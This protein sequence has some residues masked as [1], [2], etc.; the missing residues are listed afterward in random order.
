MS[1]HRHIPMAAIF[2]IVLL[3]TACINPFQTSY[4]ESSADQSNSSGQTTTLRVSSGGI[5]AATIAPDLAVLKGQ[6][7]SYTLTLTNVTPGT[8]DPIVI[9][10]YVEGTPINGIP[11]PSN[12]TLSLQGFNASAELVAEGTPVGGNPIVFPDATPVNVSV[13]LAPLTA[14][15]GELDFTLDW[16]AAA[17][18]G[19]QVDAVE[20]TL[21]SFANAV[22]ESLILSVGNESLTFTNISVSTTATATVNF[23]TETL[24]VTDPTLNSGSYRLNAT[25]LKV[26]G[27]NIPYAPV[28][29]A[30]QIY[31]NL[32]SSGTVSL[33]AGDLTSPPAAPENLSATISGEGE[34]ELNWI[35]AANT[36]TGYRVYQ[37][38][39]GQVGGDLGPNTTSLVVPGLT[40]GVPYTFEVAAFN[41]YGE[42]T[43]ATGSFVPV[44]LGGSPVT[45]TNGPNTND[46]SWAALTNPGT[47]D[48]NATFEGA[49]NYTIY[50]STNATDVAN[51]TGGVV[52]SGGTEVT[53]ALTN[54]GPFIGNTTYYY[55]IEG[56][57]SST[58]GSTGLASAMGEF[59][60]RDGNLYVA[61]AGT[62]GAAGSVV[63]PLDTVTAAIVL[64]EIGETLR[65]TQGIFDDGPIAITQNLTLEGSYETTAYT[66]RTA[67]ATTTITAT[68][69][70]D[71]AVA[72]NAQVV[73]DRI[74]VRAPDATGGPVALRF[75]GGDLSL[76]GSRVMIPNGVVAGVGIGMGIRVSGATGSI[77]VAD[78][79]VSLGGT[80]NGE[81]RGIWH[82]NG[83]VSIDVSNTDFVTDTLDAS[84]LNWIE[85]SA[86][87]LARSLNVS[88][89]TFGGDVV[90]STAESSVLVVAGNAPNTS[91]VFSENTITPINNGDQPLSGVRLQGAVGPV[92]VRLSSFDM[93]KPGGGNV[94]AL[95]TAGAGG[96]TPL[97]EANRI[98]VP[99]RTTSG[100]SYGVEV[101]GDSGA[102]IAN[103]VIELSGTSAALAS[104]GIFTTSPNTRVVNNTIVVGQNYGAGAATHLV[105]FQ[106]G[107]TGIVHNNI[108]WSRP[109]ALH[110]GIQNAVGNSMTAIANV[111]SGTSD[112]VITVNS[113]G[114]LDA[115]NMGID[116]G[117]DTAAVF[118][119]PNWYSPIA[120]TATGTPLAVRSLVLAGGI[121]DHRGVGGLAPVDIDGNPRFAGEV[122]IGAHQVA[123]TTLIG[124][125]GPAGG[126]VFYENPNYRDL[127][128][129]W[130]F[131]EAA[132]EDIGGGTPTT[133]A[134]SDPMTLDVGTNIGIGSGPN[135]TNLIL[136][137]LGAQV[138]RAAQV[139][140]VYLSNGFVDWF[141]A[142]RDELN[143]MY[144]NL[145]ADNLGGFG[146]V[147][148]W[149]SSQATAD[150][151][152][153]QRF[154]SGVQGSQNKNLFQRVRPARRF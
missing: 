50:V 122:S 115:G 143:F 17:T 146:D 84:H 117:L 109:P 52:D 29:E 3:L 145:R 38:G 123:G 54:A 102:D 124:A 99:A 87:T 10:N 126:L 1:L 113:Q 127:V 53:Y 85:V 139:A 88:G 136:G 125:V 47:L 74:E 36:E 152:H 66:T 4:D 24:T 6:I 18:A 120:P 33:S 25:L 97:F 150:T 55:L 80:L 135:N 28:I 110:T 30:V 100:T 57:N 121:D 149:S 86:S 39:F 132:P 51:R 14:G 23:V 142:S 114:T 67:N 60:I 13:V 82:T 101:T 148:Y 49:E 35:D 154:D 22:G 144:Q 58:V 20:V 63:D 119:D 116:P 111:F 147:Y 96:Q 89:S 45:F 118:P 9:N 42:S 128:E 129:E 91:I 90:G 83:S 92:S 81:V 138:N 140:D 31:G 65:M 73:L 77:T 62:P 19:I 103:N 59:T 2:S 94:R 46:P 64:A 151:A 70:H 48:W 79:V 37:I 44:S 98:R 21:Y 133:H 56:W 112:D 153:N 78:S 106:T 16:S 26:D 41:A 8:H 134:W 43:R 137:A 61:P 105:W 72:T 27:I 141:L 107:S 108:L 5:G 40:G 69:Q 34:L 32:L 68:G 93:M 11:V 12:W 76:T 15:T 104:Y 71:Y 95:A 75:D 131:L 7:S 130:R